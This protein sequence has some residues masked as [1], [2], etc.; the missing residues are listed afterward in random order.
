MG[1]LSKILI[2][3]FILSMLMTWNFPEYS[4]TFTNTT[5][6]DIAYRMG[7]T[8]PSDVSDMFN[9]TAGLNITTGNTTN[10]TTG[11]VSTITGMDQ[12]S[13]AAGSPLTAFF[14]IMQPIFVILAYL[15]L[16]LSFTFAPITMLNIMPLPIAIKL[17]I[18]VPIAILYIAAIVS[19]ISGRDI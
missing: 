9:V 2:F 1:N 11:T 5:A 17:L 19:L 10:S 6:Y 13:Q 15:Q 16:I 18:G 12:V 4:T 7:M 3:M 14:S 8:L